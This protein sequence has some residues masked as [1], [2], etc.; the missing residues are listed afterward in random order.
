M[1]SRETFITSHTSAMQISD[2]TNFTTLV[3][4]ISEIKF[5]HLIKEIKAEENKYFLLSVWRDILQ[6]EV[7]LESTCSISID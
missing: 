7:A 5:Y 3:Q 1:F 2:V 6:L 4:S